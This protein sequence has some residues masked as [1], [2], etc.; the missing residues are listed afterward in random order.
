MSSDLTR[1]RRRRVRVR[2]SRI[3]RRWNW[4][5]ARKT[6][7]LT[8]WSWIGAVRQDQWVRTTGTRNLWRTRPPEGEDYG[9]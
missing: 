3:R 5:L 6:K 4:K 7:R 2:Y 9:I 1:R 8:G